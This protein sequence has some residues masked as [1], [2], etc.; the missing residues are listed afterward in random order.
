MNVLVNECEL[1][2]ERWGPAALDE[3][4]ERIR[5]HLGRMM[6]GVKNG[7]RSSLKGERPTRLIGCGIE[8]YVRSPRRSARSRT[9]V[10]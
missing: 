6:A 7:W 1:N 9:R 3:R 8:Q 4:R 5:E 2:L 10:I